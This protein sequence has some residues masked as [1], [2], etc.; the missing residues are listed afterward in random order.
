MTVWRLASGG[1]MRGRMRQHHAI[2]L[3]RARASPAE[4][5]ALWDDGPSS[6]ERNS[7]SVRS[8]LRRRCG[9]VELNRQAGHFH[10]WTPL[11]VRPFF[12]IARPH[13][14]HLFALLDGVLTPSSPPPG[15]HH[16]PRDKND[17]PTRLLPQGRATVIST[18][19]VPIG[20]ACGSSTSGDDA[21]G[22]VYYLN[23]K[24]EA[25]D[26]WT[27]LA[28]EYTKE[29]GVEV[30]VQTAASGTYEQTLKSEIAKTEAPTLFQVN[31]PVGYQNWKK[32]T[33]DMS[34][35]DVYKE[36]ANQD[37][38]LKDG[39]KV[40]GVPYVMETYGLIYNKDIL[41]KY[42]ALD[43]A[44]ATSMDEIDN[45]DTLKAVAD[46]MQA[47]K[48]ELGIKGAFTS[49]GFDSSSD[50]RFK[51]HL[52]NLPLYYEFKDD[53]VTEQPAKIK[54][55]Y[56]PNYKKIFDLYIADST[57]DPTQLSAKTGD[58]A[59]SE[60]AL[61]EAAFYQ[62]GTW[63]WTDLQKA[64]MKAESV[65]MMPIYTGVKGEEKQGLA[66]GSENYWCINDKAS[67]ADKKAT[68]DFLSWVIT[69]DTGKKAI[70]QDMGFT[71]PFKTFDDVKFDNPLTEAAVEDQKSGKTQV[72]WNFTM[73]PSEE[74][75]N[76]VGQALLE[77][78][79]GTGKWDAVKT[80]F[81]DGWASEYE[82]SH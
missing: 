4:S 51:T 41:N 60:F 13:T 58:D 47:R 44:K 42:F 55:T 65:G 31:G 19:K 61:G 36:L 50:W 57:T 43:G 67:D 70:S 34:N 45:F 10:R 25:A 76:K 46:D 48:D 12:F 75:K 33:A 53:N 16:F 6:Q 3:R 62:N 81:V 59:N 26:Q 82:A 2:R 35:T 22:K 9:I 74:W 63:A 8:R 5:A 30:K 79:Q 69:S 18:T 11:P 29:K 17:R 15:A 66:T 38:A 64:G 80:A 23:F 73:M 72:S 40:V 24:P 1:A 52:A 14:G 77:Y 7:S 37:V 78:A 56:L 32:Y 71:T 54:G 27:A 39:D 20:P 49:A 21:K 68:E 28:K